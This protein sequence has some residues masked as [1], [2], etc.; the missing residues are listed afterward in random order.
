MM[1]L[2]AMTPATAQPAIRRH[3]IFAFAIVA[4]ATDELPKR[5]PA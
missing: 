1:M 5:L 3:A 4:G 2:I